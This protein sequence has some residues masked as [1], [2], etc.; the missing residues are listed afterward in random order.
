PERLDD[1][2]GRVD[3]P[4]GSVEVAAVILHVEVGELLDVAL[5]GDTAEEGHGHAP[6]IVFHYAAVGRLV[7]GAGEAVPVTAARGDGELIELK[8]DHARR[9]HRHVRLDELHVRVQR[10]GVTLPPPDRLQ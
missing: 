4:V 2:L 9:G 10:G 7:N 3:L 6:H 5:V 8:G 1:R